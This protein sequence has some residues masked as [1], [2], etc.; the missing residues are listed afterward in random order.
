MK[1]VVDSGN[2]IPA[3]RPRPSCALGCEVIEL[4]SEVDGDLPNHH[5]DPSKPENPADLIRSVKATG[6]ELAWPSTATVT[7]SASSRSTAT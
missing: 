3:P 2:G 7:A 4:Y 1:I 6:A 5:P